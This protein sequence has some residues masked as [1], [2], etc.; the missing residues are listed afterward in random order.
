MQFCEVSVV[1]KASCL[2]P[3]KMV[4]QSKISV[5]K[6]EFLVHK[7]FQGEHLS[8]KEADGANFSMMIF[9]NLLFVKIFQVLRSLIFLIFHL[10]S[11]STHVCTE[12]TITKTYGRCASLFS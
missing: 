2:S 9:S 6:F 7:L 8:E 1:K 4:K 3:V 11:F 10:T 12:S 5:A